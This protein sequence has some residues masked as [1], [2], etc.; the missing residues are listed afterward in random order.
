M[1]ERPIMPWL[2]IMVLA[3]AT[4]SAG[5][6]SSSPPSLTPTPTPEG[7]DPVPMAV[8]FTLQDCFMP[9]VRVPAATT[10]YDGSMPA[11]FTLVPDDPATYS[12][13]YSGLTCD[14]TNGRETPAGLSIAAVRV[15]PPAG[16]MD[17]TI[18]DYE[19]SDG[20]MVQ[21]DILA[22]LVSWGNGTPLLFVEAVLTSTQTSVGGTATG[23]VEGKTSNI[24]VTVGWSVAGPA[25]QQPGR[26]YRLFLVDSLQVPFR[27][28]GAI[29]VTVTDS[30]VRSGT[31]YVQA[32]DIT[33]PVPNL[34]PGTAARVSSG[35]SVQMRPVP[36]T[37]G[38]SAGCRDSC[39]LKGG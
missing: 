25:Q 4:A 35:F 21:G 37:P 20:G 30:S 28:V 8:G 14:R 27:L 29:D 5:C 39:A 24:T 2:P 15:V 13:E 10:L 18:A 33:F 36:G 32:T 7:K 6:L 26:T 22:P 16:L 23:S 1:I 9:V 38:G 17:P 31:G 12:I 19:M 34:L 11:G 3:L